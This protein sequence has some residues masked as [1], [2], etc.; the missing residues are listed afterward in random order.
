MERISSQELSRLMHGDSIPDHVRTLIISA[1]SDSRA[2]A[3]MWNIC[4]QEIGKILGL[5]KKHHLIIIGAGN[6]GQ[7]L[8]N[9]MNFECRGF[10][11]YRNL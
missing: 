3:I 7:A 1:A 4:T 5:D 10:I 2:T 8:A 11:F 6:L 9:Y